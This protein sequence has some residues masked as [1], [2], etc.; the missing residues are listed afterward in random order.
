MENFRKFTLTNEG[1]LFLTVASLLV[2]AVALGLFTL[3]GAFDTADEP[4]FN[5]ET[6]AKEQA[7]ELDRHRRTH[8]MMDSIISEQDRTIYLLQDSIRRGLHL[9]TVIT[10]IGI[11]SP[12]ARKVLKPALPHQ[13]YWVGR[14]KNNDYGGIIGFF[15]VV[16]IDG[17]LYMDC[18]ECRTDDKFELAPIEKWFTN[19][20]H[21][22]EAYY[23]IARKFDFEYFGKDIPINEVIASEGFQNGEYIFDEEYGT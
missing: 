21:L 15:G 12:R 6:I 19:P 10:R 11:T 1:A 3:F 2:F 4:V 7:K 20:V 14:N 8:L 16:V 18:N 13:G 23:E 9:D 5:W 17:K 22:E